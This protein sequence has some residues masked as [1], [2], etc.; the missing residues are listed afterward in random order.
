MN[1]LMKTLIGIAV[2][3][4]LVLIFMNYV[5]RYKIHSHTVSVMSATTSIENIL[6][7]ELLEEPS[8]GIFKFSKGELNVKDKTYKTSAGNVTN[9]SPVIERI[10]VNKIDKVLLI[11]GGKQEF[12]AKNLYEFL[13]ILKSSKTNNNFSKVY[14]KTMKE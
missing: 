14:Y 13:F 2:A 6:N 9:I 1:E 11:K 5:E 3:G 10:E 4:I 8:E 7:D 12:T